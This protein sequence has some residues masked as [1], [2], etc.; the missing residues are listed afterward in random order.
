MAGVGDQPRC[1]WSILCSYHN[2]FDQETLTQATGRYRGADGPGDQ[3]DHSKSIRR[4]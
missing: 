3:G 4:L 1:M 2:H